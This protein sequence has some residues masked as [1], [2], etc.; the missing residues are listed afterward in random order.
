MPSRDALLAFI[1]DNPGRVGKRD[2]A[3][4]FGISGSHQRAEL[5]RLLRELKDEGQ[6]GRSAGKRLELA[7]DLPSELIVEVIQIDD[8]GIAIAEPLMWQ[9]DSP[10]PKI[11]LK[12]QSGGR[13]S[14]APGLGDRAIIQVRHLADGGYEGH[15]RRVLS[16]DP[17]QVVGV[18][19]R[20]PSGDRIQPTD[21]KQRNEYHTEVPA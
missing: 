16:P 8:E 12:A 2:I 20:T 14:P 4:A 15:V 3:R 7:G 10:P 13:S 19:K 18:F 6:I 11:P 17:Q 5:N 21:R 1:A 9:A